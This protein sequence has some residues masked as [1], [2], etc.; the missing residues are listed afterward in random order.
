MFTRILLGV[1]LE[2]KARGVE[3]KALRE[4]LVER[5]PALPIG[6]GL[7]LSLCR[8]ERFESELLKLLVELGMVRD[9]DRPQSGGNV[10]PAA[11][12]FNGD[13]EAN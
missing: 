13:P 3:G 6:F 4:V 1:A 8:L 12:S 5:R 11:I 9:Y 2:A 7:L 10:P